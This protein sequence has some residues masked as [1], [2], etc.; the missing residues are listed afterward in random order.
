[1]GL[2][3]YEMIY[4]RGP[5]D[6]V[7]EQHGTRAMFYIADSRMAIQY[8]DCPRLHF[9]NASLTKNKENKVECKPEFL[10]MEA[11]L[12]QCLE[13]DA[14]QR[15][16]VETIQNE[17]GKLP[18]VVRM[19]LQSNCVTTMKKKS[20]VPL[21]PTSSPTRASNALNKQPTTTESEAGYRYMFSPD[22]LPSPSSHFS[23]EPMSQNNN[24]LRSELQTPLIKLADAD[25]DATVYLDSQIET[26]HEKRE[27]DIMA[28]CKQLLE[29]CGINPE[30]IQAWKEKLGVF[31]APA[32]ANQVQEP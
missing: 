14:E 7:M 24:Y 12:Q 26:V 17:L 27:K 19:D 28:S 22:F 32:I 11:I 3:L 9:I 15:C 18:P 2:I 25:A 30:N 8:P 31:E 5:Y 13:R 16:E 4:L 6:G 21:P 1:M 29:E 23:T 20:D 10:H